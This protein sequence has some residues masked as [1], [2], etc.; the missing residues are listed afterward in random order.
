MAKASYNGPMELTMKD[1]GTM[2]KLRV[3]V[4]SEKVELST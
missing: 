3:K 1:N 4:S 2:I